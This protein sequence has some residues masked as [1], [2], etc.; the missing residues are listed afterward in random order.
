[1]LG[2]S[3]VQNHAKLLTCGNTIN[4]APGVAMPISIYGKLIEPILR[5]LAAKPKLALTRTN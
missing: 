4:T 1:M 2:V 5:Y 3:Q